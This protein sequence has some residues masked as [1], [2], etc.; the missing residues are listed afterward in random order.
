[1]PGAGDCRTI[2][3]SPLAGRWY[4]ASAREIAREIAGWEDYRGADCAAAAVG[5]P[6]RTKA[7]CTVP[8]AG[9]YFS[10]RLAARALEAAGAVLGPEGPE[11]AVVLGGHL[12]PGAPVIAYAEDAWETPLGP[13][14]LAPGLVPELA[15]ASGGRLRFRT[16]EGPT[17]DNTVEVELPLVKHFFPR[18]RVLAL[19]A[20]PDRSAETLAG[21]LLDVLR[22]RK[23]LFVAST[24]LTH[25]GDAY[26]FSPAGPGPAGERFREENDR[27]FVEAA[28]AMDAG[29]MLNLGNRRSAAC[30]AGA[31]AA[32][33]RI[34]AELK[35]AG[36]LIDYYASTDILPGEQSVGYAGIVYAP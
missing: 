17:G 4:P 30:S 13:V 27:A 33:G 9:W 12:P 26:G 1:M 18:A 22:D 36:R 29:A 34:A 21:A 25:Y 8:H 31:A 5:G 32:I 10:G 28:L 19:R 6:P 14:E 2:R 11:V 7:L 24:D 20:A 23:T 15:G 3:R 35:A 16:W